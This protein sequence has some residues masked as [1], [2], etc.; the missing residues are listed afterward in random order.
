MFP[1]E[2]QWTPFSGHKWKQGTVGKHM[3]CCIFLSLQPGGA[4]QRHLHNGRLECLLSL[5]QMQQPCARGPGGAGPAFSDLAHT[6]CWDGT[7]ESE[8]DRKAI[9]WAFNL[10]FRP[11]TP[12][13]APPHTHT[14]SLVSS[15]KRQKVRDCFCDH[16]IYFLFV[17]LIYVLPMGYTQYQVWQ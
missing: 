8:N 3:L 13:P 2:M 16:V 1:P 4:L 11:P 5:P 12:P 9:P 14:P 17:Y 7:E 6:P 15:G 10:P